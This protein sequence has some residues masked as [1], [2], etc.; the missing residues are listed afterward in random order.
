[1]S[2]QHCYIRTADISLL[3]IKPIHY[4]AVYNRLQGFLFCC[5][6]SFGNQWEFQSI[7]QL[8]YD[9]ELDKS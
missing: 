8:D 6:G 1:M 4:K 7:D 2:H 5:I 3:S 9:Y